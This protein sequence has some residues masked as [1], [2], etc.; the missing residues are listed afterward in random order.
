MSG[1]LLNENELGGFIDQ[2][3]R[4]RGDVLFR[5]ERLPH[6]A[7]AQQ[8]AEL[9][10]WRNGGEPDMVAKQRWLDVLAAEVER[11]M[12]T[13]RLRI[14]SA[15]LSDDEQRACHWGYPHVGRFEDVRVLRSGEHPVP[16]LLDHDYWVI[17][18]AGSDVQVV[19]MDYS[20]CGEFLGATVL[21]P[22]EHPLY[23]HEQHL[24]WANAEPFSAWWGRHGEL[25]RRRSAA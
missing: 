11:G 3:Y 19:R 6:Y 25:H 16:D 4:A 1:R 20:G 22:A 18:P 21:P 2:H 24:A 5:M 10:A 7:V 9:Q 14:L 23:L 13:Q 17:R 15:D 12:L 8:S